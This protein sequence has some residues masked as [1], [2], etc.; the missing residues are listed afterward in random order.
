MTDYIIK[1]G[2][3]DDECYDVYQYG[4]QVGLEML[5]CIVVCC[6]ISMYLHMVP[7]FIVFI[8]VFMLLRTYAG[9]MHLNSF[10]SCFLCSVTTQT[11][12]LLFSR[13]YMFSFHVSWA[14]IL[15]GTFLIL[16]AAPVESVN[17][18]LEDDEKRHCK[19][20]TRNGLISIILFSVGC[21]LGGMRDIVSLISLAI[22]QVLFSQYMGIVKYKFERKSGDRE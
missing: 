3:V 20:I 2:V 22:L 8:L 5:S 21:T 19:K 9:G 4:F 18:E 10:W 14:V 6:G 16:K 17:R 12:V 7:E 15:S 1:T 11:A 13:E